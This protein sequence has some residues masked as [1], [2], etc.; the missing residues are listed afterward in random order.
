MAVWPLVTLKLFAIDAPPP[1]AGFVT[2][3]GYVPTVA[4]SAEVSEIVS[5]PA[6]TNVAAWEMPLKV[7]VEESRNPVPLIVN[8]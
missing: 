8:V 1:G 5:W 2:T 6:L 7:T 3:T 4:R